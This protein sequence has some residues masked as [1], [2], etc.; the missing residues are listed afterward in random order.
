MLRKAVCISVVG[1]RPSP[2]LFV[3]YL[4]LARLLSV[5]SSQRRI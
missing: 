3:I 4:S 5:L 1:T 2:S